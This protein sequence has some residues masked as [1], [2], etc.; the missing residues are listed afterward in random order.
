MPNWSSTN[1]TIRGSEED[2]RSFR[3]GVQQIGDDLSIIK[4]Y[5]PCPQPLYDATSM[6]AF[7]VIPEHWS[8]SVADGTWTQEDYDNRVAENAR[9]LVQQKENLE[10]YGYKDW[11]DWQIDNWG[12]KWGDCDT[13]IFDPI[14]TGHEDVWCTQGYFQ[15]PWGTATNA[16]KNISKQFPKCSFEFHSEEEAGF[17][18][19][20]EVIVNGEVVYENYYEPCNYSEEIDWDDEKSVE[21]YEDWKAEKEN[22]IHQDFVLHLRNSGWMPAL[23][24]PTRFV[25]TGKPH[26]WK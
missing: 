1:F 12:V 7:D 19:G 22:E 8:K 4:S 24:P 9:L 23:K 2:V 16:W 6:S 10:K 13:E 17:F 21:K 14:H 3:K 15:T 18:T 11:W 5:L 26:F 20:T 25:P